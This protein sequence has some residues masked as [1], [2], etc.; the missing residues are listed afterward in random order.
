MRFVTFDDGLLEIR[1][2]WLPVFIGQSVHVLKE[3]EIA[4]RAKFQ[5]VEVTDSVLDEIHQWVV[6]WLCRRFQIE[7]LR[8][9][10]QGICHVRM[11]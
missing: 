4:G 8:E 5:G 10:L 3:L 9:Y 7:G 11:E 1:F 2:M 6:E